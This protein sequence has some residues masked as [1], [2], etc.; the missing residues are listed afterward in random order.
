MRV[1]FLNVD[2][3][4]HDDEPPELWALA[5]VV[6]VACGGHAG[7]ER[8]M[9]RIVTACAGGS[10]AIGA[11]PSY[12]DREG[13]GRTTLEL[14]P[15]ELLATLAEQCHALASVARRAGVA[16]RHAKLHG[17][18]YHDANRDPVRADA[19][20]RAIVEALGWEIAILGP[21][22]GALRARAQELGLAFLG[23]G[24][25][26]RGVHADGTLLPRGT[27]GALIDQP[28]R[29]VARARVLAPEVDT[30]CVHGDGPNAL[31][32]ARAVRALLDG[33]PDRSP[34]AR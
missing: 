18:L 33:I 17:A 11:H 34:R 26:D 30:I 29:A 12:P 3:G 4:E 13:F 5:H 6:N 15:A 25:A 16:I 31:A 7:D 19:A 22:A 2:A 21:P 8:S 24:F 20:L 1:P 32:V 14:G 9:E 28:E 10:T 27:P 23:E